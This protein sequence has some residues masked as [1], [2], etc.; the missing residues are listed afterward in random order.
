MSGL[1]KTFQGNRI[2]A[3]VQKNSHNTPFENLQANNKSLYNY[4]V[5]TRYYRVNSFM[6]NAEKG[7]TYFKNLVVFKLQ[8]FQS[9]F[10]YFSILFIQ[11]LSHS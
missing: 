11:R 6:C 5:G 1:K 2:T 3:G 7:Q 9:M 4:L 10:G 8:N